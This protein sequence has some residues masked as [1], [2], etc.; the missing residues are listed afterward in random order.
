MKRGI[1]YSARMNAP[2]KD[3]APKLK[4]PRLTASE[5][6]AL[7]QITPKIRAFIEDAIPDL[8]EDKRFRHPHGVTRYSNHALATGKELWVKKIDP[9]F[10]NTTKAGDWEGHRVMSDE[11]AR[12]LATIIKNVA[13]KSPELKKLRRGCKTRGFNFGIEP[14]E[15]RDE[16]RLPIDSIPIHEVIVAAKLG[17]ELN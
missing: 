7:A 2:T 15:Y 17:S 16:I 9:T 4:R 11:A 13:S 8:K 6:A 10:E 12:K 5:R 3:K 1:R 14:F